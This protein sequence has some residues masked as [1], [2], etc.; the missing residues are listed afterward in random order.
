[1]ET[2]ESPCSLLTSNWEVSTGG[3]HLNFTQNTKTFGIS[4]YIYDIET[5]LPIGK[6]TLG[7][8]T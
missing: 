4:S 1:M 5:N 3:L 2:F 6:H 8:F 7:V